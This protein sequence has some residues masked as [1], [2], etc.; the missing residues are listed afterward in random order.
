MMARHRLQLL[1]RLRHR[2]SRLSLLPF[3]LGRIHP[4]VSCLKRPRGGSWSGLAARGET[5]RRFHLVLL[6]GS[7][8]PPLSSLLLPTTHEKYVIDP[9][10]RSLVLNCSRPRNRWDLLGSAPPTVVG[11]PP[12]RLGMSDR[13]RPVM[14]RCSWTGSLIC[15]DR[16]RQGD[17]RRPVTSITPLLSGVSVAGLRETNEADK[18]KPQT[19]DAVNRSPRSSRARRHRPVAMHDFVRVIR[20]VVDGTE[21]MDRRVC[22]CRNA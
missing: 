22:E 18:A 20:R 19:I 16:F 3:G 4:F 5:V 11:T 2:S 15:S 7:S 12:E 21:S 9:I 17:D 10:Y 8:H 13:I 6:E 1:H 14:R